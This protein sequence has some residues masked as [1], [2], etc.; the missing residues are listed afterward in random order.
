MTD[1]DQRCAVHE[2]GHAGACLCLGIPITAVTIDAANPHCTRARYR[3]QHEAGLECLVTMCLAGPMAE[4]MACGPITD[5]GDQTDYQMARDYLARRFG[6]LQIGAEIARLRDAAA[7]LVRTQWARQRIETIA[8]ALL[9]LQT[10][11]GAQI[12]AL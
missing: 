11:T 2:A 8:A 3:P 4:V 1:A 9:Q 12:E 10:L 6:P 5:G 7:R